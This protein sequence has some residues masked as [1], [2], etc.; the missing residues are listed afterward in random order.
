MC[1]LYAGH[2]ILVD[3]PN[4]AKAF[5]SASGAPFWVYAADARAQ[6]SAS[7]KQNENDIIGN[8]SIVI[9]E[10]PAGQGSG[11]ILGRIG[12]Q[13]L[14]ATSGHV[15]G[16]VNA[17]ERFE[18][19]TGRGKRYGIN[20][21]DVLLS[22]RYD[23]AFVKF[24]TSDCFVP[25]PT[26]S[27][28]SERDSHPARQGEG[29]LVAGYSSVDKFISDKPLLRVSPGNIAVVIE[30]QDAKNGYTLG[31]SNP[32]SRGMS[33]GAIFQYWNFGLVGPFLQGIHGRGEF[34]SLQAIKTGMNF[35]IGASTLVAEAKALRVDDFIGQDRI[36]RGTPKNM[37]DKSFSEIDKRCPLAW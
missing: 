34:D 17:S 18:I 9:L 4:H 24:S 3:V 14:I 33:G 13:Y 8:F 22:K 37:Q 30:A 28:Q 35:G 1:L 26:F 16:D 2:H 29:I 19:V 25:L 27:S 7:A 11:V 23:L 32:T 10:T 5:A 20:M 12:N 6:T 21:R 15:L 31:Y 36:S